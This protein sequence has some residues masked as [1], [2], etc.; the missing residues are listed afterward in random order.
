[1]LHGECLAGAL[2][3]CDFLDLAMAAGFGDPRLVSDRPL[4]VSDPMIAQKVAPTRRFGC[5]GFSAA[6][7]LG[8]FV[9]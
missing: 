1:M 9:S 2:N 3:W 7:G 5:T 8:D 4:A 6:D